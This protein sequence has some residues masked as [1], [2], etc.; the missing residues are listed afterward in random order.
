MIKTDDSILR[1]NDIYSVVSS[2]VERK[3]QEANSINNLETNTSKNQH[4]KQRFVE[5]IS[6]NFEE[7][8]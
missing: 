4:K 6:S 7:E 3:I 5:V 2:I 8:N 1:I